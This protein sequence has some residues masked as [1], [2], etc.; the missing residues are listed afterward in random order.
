M[1][2]KL[3]RILGISGDRSVEAILRAI[4]AERGKYISKDFYSRIK[5][6]LDMMWDIKRN[7]TIIK[8]EREFET[9]FM[10][11]SWVNDHI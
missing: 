8:E 7:K 3:N 6:F 11:M 2:R 4:H 5:R 9:L 1:D 10:E